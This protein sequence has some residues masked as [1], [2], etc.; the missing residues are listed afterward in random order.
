MEREGG[1][2]P[3]VSARLHRPVERSVTAGDGPGRC[4]A[5]TPV[6]RPSPPGSRLP[7][8]AS[9][10]PRPRR[11]GPRQDRS[12]GGGAPSWP[13]CWARSPSRSPPWPPPPVSHR[14]GTDGPAD[15][16][17]RRARGASG[18]TGTRA[19]SPVSPR[20]VPRRARVTRSGCPSRLRP[21]LR[22]LPAHRGTA[23]PGGPHRLRPARVRGVADAQCV[24][25]GVT[26]SATPAAVTPMPSRDSPL[27]RSPN[28]K[29]AS[30]AVAGGTR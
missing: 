27:T 7:A 12:G 16:W 6:P 9:R 14:T 30:T 23:R 4:R 8:A 17:R 2:D 10:H 20:P 26:T 19:P 29:Y 3:R 24:R 22:R 11:A 1:H 15:R 28:R 21:P 13:S 18:P 5:A 25:D